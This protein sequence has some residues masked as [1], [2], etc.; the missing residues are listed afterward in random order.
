MHGLVSLL[1]KKY[2]TEVENLWNEL[3]D[4]FGLRGI[5]VTPYPHFS[6]FVVEKF[7]SK[8]LEQKMQ[9]LS[10]KLKPFILKTAGIGI[11]TGESPVIYISIIKNEQLLTQHKMIY[12]E[13]SG[14]VDGIVPFYSPNLWVPHISIGYTDITKENIGEVMEYLSFKNF[15]W[16]MKIN[17]Y[18]FIYEPTGSI[19]QLRYKFSFKK[20]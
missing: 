19:G 16:E 18:G 12:Q 5:K 4:R 3:E 1:E 11:F 10:K 14:A 15:H 13:L 17:N 8:M 6:W 9:E 20:Y 2:Y 7:N